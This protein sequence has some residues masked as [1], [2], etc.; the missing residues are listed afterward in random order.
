MLTVYIGYDE[1]EPI[2]YDVLEYSIRRH[3][4]EPVNIQ[5][6]HLDT[7]TKKGLMTRPFEK[8]NGRFYDP[9][10]EAPASTEF[11]ISRFLAPV[12]Q[13][14]GWAI[15]MDCDMVFTDDICDIWQEI[16]PRYAVQCVK[17]EHKPTEAMKMDGQ[18]QTI[19]RRKNWSSFF[20]F[21]A[22]HEANKR[23]TLEKINTLAGRDLH[24]FCW[25]K[26][27]EIGELHHG[28]NWLVN[29]EPKPQKLYNAHF[30]LGGPWFPEWKAQPNDDLWN[31]YLLDYQAECMK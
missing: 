14:S 19:Y 9:I 7:L 17:H 2:A 28:W 5:P 18:A 10:S 22:D 27:N 21:N 4:S 3:A 31:C 20:V 23:L 8:K 30:T 24:A 26:D 1:R 25:L 16:D 15:F 29:V 13:Q 12:L 11:A 6:L